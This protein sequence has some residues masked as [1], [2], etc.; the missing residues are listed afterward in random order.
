MAKFIPR[1]QKKYHDEVVPALREKHDIKN[2]MA[3]PRLKKI[4]INMGIGE[5]TQN[6]KLPETLAT[7][8]G[9]IA[10]QKPVITRAKRAAATWKLRENDAIGAMVTLRGK[11][12]WLFLEKLISVAVPRIRDFSGLKPD[13]FD[14]HGNYSMGIQEQTLF[15]DIEIDKIAQVQGMDICFTISGGNDEWSR[16]LLMGL[17]MPLKKVED[18]KSKKKAA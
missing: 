5:G 13:S 17:G 10:G 7:D 6:K 2:I 18:K 8:L 9:I 3:V 4:T 14:G 15:P 12:M 11:N 1:L 16:S